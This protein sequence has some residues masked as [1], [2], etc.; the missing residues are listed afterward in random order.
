[1]VEPN[2]SAPTRAGFAA[3]ALVAHWRAAGY[4]RTEP[5]IL[6]PASVF[7]DLVGED[8][9]GRLYVTA[10]A[11]GSESCLR[12]E[13]TIP[14]ARAYLAGSEA[15]R[16]AE[17]HCIG[18]VFRQ[19]PGR[20]DEFMQAGIESFGRTDS[21]AADADVLALA[22]EGVAEAGGPKLAARLGD[23]KL[24]EAFLDGVGLAAPARRRLKRALSRG[25]APEAAL[26]APPA[27]GADHS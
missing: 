14:V 1:M 27:Q 11:E 10:D 20:D 2:D 25:E 21:A 16:R 3:A 9:R 24:L 26:A 4:A 8:L 5:P 18:P 13:F 17:Y 23:A 15:G 6:Q 22:L 19:R 7:Y 12:P